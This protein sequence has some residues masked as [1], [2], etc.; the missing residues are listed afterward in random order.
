MSHEILMSVEDGLLRVAQVEDAELSNLQ[1]APMGQTASDG[2]SLIGQIYLGQV[3][4]V[5]SRLQAAFVDIGMDRAGFLGAREA[6]ALLP[7]SDRET[8]I[9]DC[10]QDGDTVLVQI[11]RPP[12]GEKGAQIT[13]DITLPGRA[14]VLAPCRSRIAV[15]RQI[16]DEAER[17]RLA[18]L[19]DAIRDGKQGDGLDVEGMDGPAGWVIRTAAI[20]MEA[21]DMAADMASVAGQWE[22]L[23]AQAEDSEPPAVL[24]QDLG[25]VEK[26]LRDLVRA[27]TTAVVIEDAE[28]L[29]Q[30]KAFASAHM[31]AAVSL[32]QGSE[33]GEILFDRYDIAGQLEQA[34]SN[35]VS[36]ASG[37]WLMIETTEAM[38]TIDVNSGG[39]TADARG[40][41]LE[42]AQAIGRQ[43]RLRALGGLVAI[44][45][46]DMSE[47]ADNEAVLAALDAGFQ[48]DKNPI[49]IGPMSEFGVVEMTRRRDVMSLAEAMRQR[50]RSDS[51]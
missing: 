1:A 36:L 26:A 10:V 15:S 3:E 20:G 19:A 37:G 5:V 44:D 50:S 38:T 33:K 43:L 16:E 28:S 42:A 2:R 31:P 14:V 12:H 39:D 17:T 22:T 13:S 27:Q 35:R 41:N 18:D 9:E 49:R 40:V 32:L 4:R 34:L 48:G 21:A 47:D 6:R 24:Y 51:E 45:F 23:L 29:A 8:P 25:P 11:T 7:G 46:I 30:A